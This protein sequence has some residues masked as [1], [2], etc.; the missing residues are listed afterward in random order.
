MC[1][2]LVPRSSYPASSITKASAYDVQLVA[3]HA[4]KV[5]T[6]TQVANQEIAAIG[7]H[8]VA[9]MAQDSSLGAALL[10]SINRLREV[11]AAVALAVCRVAADEGLARVELRDPVQ[12]VFE[13]MWR[14]E[15]AT[16]VI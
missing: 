6:I 16:V 9:A 4:A 5:T 11:S 14:P 1:A 3:E 2:D 7:S 15:Y 10:P 8:A 13:S 12:Q